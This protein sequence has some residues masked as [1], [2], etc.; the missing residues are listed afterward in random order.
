M[1]VFFV[2]RYCFFL[3]RFCTCLNVFAVE[4]RVLTDEI[5]RNKVEFELHF[6]FSRPRQ[7]VSFFFLLLFL[8]IMLQS[9]YSINRDAKTISFR[10]IENRAKFSAVLYNLTLP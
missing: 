4:I 2:V 3:T 1:N 7:Q 8:K 9:R 6:S 5:H 10:L